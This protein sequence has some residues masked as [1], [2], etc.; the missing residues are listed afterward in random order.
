MADDYKE[1]HILTNKTTGDR[2]QK[3]DGKWVS[4]GPTVATDIKKDILPMVARTAAGIAGAPRAAMDL[5]NKAIA[6]GAEKLGFPKY[7]D[8]LREDTDRGYGWNSISAI[9]GMQVS[10]EVLT[11]A[12]EKFTGPLY[13]PQTDTGK[14]FDAGTSGVLGGL[15]TG[16]ASVP[17]IVKSLTGA[18]GSEYLGQKFQGT[19]A[20]LPARLAGGML[21][22][23]APSV[24][25]RMNT[26]LPAEPNHL[27]RAQN[28]ERT[29][30]TQLPAGQYTGNPVWNS[31]EAPIRNW[32]GSGRGFTPQ[33]QQEAVSRALMRSTGGPNELPTVNTV[34]T[35]AR[36]LGDTVLDQT[37]NMP[38]IPLGVNANPELA[39]D[40]RDAAQRARASLRLPAN[41]PVPVVDP[42]IETMR[43]DPAT[44]LFRNRLT[45][46]EYA[47]HRHNL[48]ETARSTTPMSPAIRQAHF[49]VRDALDAAAERVSPGLNGLRER[50]ANAHALEGALAHPTADTT[51]GV[52][53]PAAFAQAHNMPNTATPTFARD[54]VS[55]LE[56][57]SW[58]RQLG[59]GVLP[60]LVGGVVGAGAHALGGITDPGIFGLL[61]APLA[62]QGL[63]YMPTGRALLSRPVQWHLRNQRTPPSQDALNWRVNDPRRAAVS[64]LTQLPRSELELIEGQE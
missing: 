14:Y 40:F 41:A 49:D 61:A 48:G 51:R 10:P 55:V 47:E 6:Y 8:K 9:P 62:A 7:A 28:Y 52:V 13:H 12:V 35:Q 29:T 24:A 58:Q 42:M 34:R 21:G 64:A 60:G 57:P 44:N 25:R 54:A 45:G 37:T 19:N 17:N 16:P 39:N 31:I 1:G 56:N 59:A 18:L 53:S 11:K 2:L 26:P 4:I 23:R 46:P 27:A 43:R 33:Q 38:H 63:T 30:G 15:A 50:Q 20:E 5:G 36:N 22:S 3:Q 32:W